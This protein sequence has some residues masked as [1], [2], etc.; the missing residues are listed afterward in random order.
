MRVAVMM[1]SF[2]GEKYI[3]QQ[4][5]SILDQENVLADIYVR[6]DGSS[7]NTISIINSFSNRVK[8]VEQGKNIRPCNSFLRLLSLTPNNYDYYA[9]S[10]QDDV[11]CPNKISKAVNILTSQNNEYSLYY[12]A[13][14]F[15]DESLEKTEL[16]KNKITNP[17]FEF[18]LIRSIFPGCTMVFSPKVKKLLSDYMFSRQIMH[19]QLVFQT[20]KGIGGYI[21]YDSDSYIYY[22]IHGNNVSVNNSLIKRIKKLLNELLIEKGKRYDALFEF[23]NLIGNMLTPGNEMVLEKYISYKEQNFFRRL[24]LGLSIRDDIKYKFICAVSFA[25][26]SF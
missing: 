18:S 20:V 26:K 22:R 1:S 12:S 24:L 25:V 16:H 11:W 10:D 8:L 2:N 14:N 6:D 17:S 21:Y 7:D 3:K 15:S 4:I 9:F 5:Q 19:D 23:N 13:L